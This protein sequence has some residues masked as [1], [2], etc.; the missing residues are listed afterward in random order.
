MLVVDAS[1]G[2]CLAGAHSSLDQDRQSLP[3]SGKLP[4]KQES[5]RWL[6]VAEAG[7]NCLSRPW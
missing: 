6:D 3:A 2:A 5:Y 7:K 1:D 4:M